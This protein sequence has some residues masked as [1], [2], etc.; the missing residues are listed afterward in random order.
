MTFKLEYWWRYND[1]KYFDII[2]IEAKTFKDACKIIHELK[3]NV[4][5]IEKLP[6]KGE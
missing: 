5:K 6:S 3:S 2:E 1:E 4:V